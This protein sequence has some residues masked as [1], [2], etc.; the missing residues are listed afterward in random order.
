[1]RINE[2][3]D[4]PV[5]PN[6]DAIDMTDEKFKELQ[7]EVCRLIEQVVLGGDQTSMMPV[8]AIN[9]REIEDNGMLS[10]PKYAMV[11]ITEHFGTK[12]EQYE[13]IREIGRTT[14][15]KRWIPAAVFMGMEAWI[16]KDVNVPPSE[17]PDRKEVIV[18]PGMTISMDTRGL[19]S[20]PITR[21]EK[22][23]LVRG[24]DNM[25]SD[26]FCAPI[27]E[28]FFSG[29]FERT[30]ARLKNETIQQGPTLSDRE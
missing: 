20:I 4:K 27:L 15:K 9:Y 17:Q 5:T 24:G 21:N 25:E 29:Y 8:I 23:F 19:V 7:K 26:K 1:M 12:K 11:G 16:G 3:S 14:E 6:I 13:T 2:P 18:I 30:A 10:D 28:G 22:G